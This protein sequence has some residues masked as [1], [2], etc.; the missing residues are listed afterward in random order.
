MCQW[1]ASE[2]VTGNVTGNVIDPNQCLL[3]NQKTLP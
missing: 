1:P 2:N 3:Y